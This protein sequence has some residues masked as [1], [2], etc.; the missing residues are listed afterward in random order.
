MIMQ[1]DKNTSLY[2]SS[3]V[4]VNDRELVTISVLDTAPEPF[5]VPTTTFNFFDEN[6]TTFSTPSPSVSY[7]DISKE[8]ARHY[9]LA[10]YCLLFFAVIR[11]LQYVFY[12][13]KRF[14][15]WFTKPEYEAM[16]YNAAV[17]EGRLVQGHGARL[18]EFLLEDP[19]YMVPQTREEISDYGLKSDRGKQRQKKFAKKDER[20]RQQITS[21]VNKL[22]KQLNAINQRMQKKKDK[23]EMDPQTEIVSD[24][25][26]MLSELSNSWAGGIANWIINPTNE[27][28]IVTTLMHIEAAYSMRKDPASVLRIVLLYVERVTPEGKFTEWAQAI[29]DYL[30]EN[31]DTMIHLRDSASQFAT[32]GAVRGIVNAMSPH[33]EPTS[34][35][36]IKIVAAS[37]TLHHIK[38]VIG[39]LVGVGLAPRG[40]SIMGVKLFAEAAATK[41]SSCEDIFSAAIS[42]IDY[43]A[44]VGRK[45]FQSG[46]W[47]DLMFE[48]SLESVHGRMAAC[49]EKFSQMQGEPID[50]FAFARML[51]DAKDFIRMKVKAESPQGR[52]ILLRHVVT[53]DSMKIDVMARLRGFKPAKAPVGMCLHGDSSVGKSTVM[54]FTSQAAAKSLGRESFIGKTSYIN[55]ATKF[56]DTIN[57]NTE[58]IVE[59]DINYAMQNVVDGV[60][61]CNVMDIMNN[62][63][64]TTNQ[65]D[66][67][68]KGMVSKTALFYMSSCNNKRQFIHG[69][70]NHPE[71]MFRR[72]DAVEVKVKPAAQDVSGRLN[73]AFVLAELDVD[74]EGVPRRVPDTV[75]SLTYEMWDFRV[76]DYRPVF[77]KYGDVCQLSLD[78]IPGGFKVKDVD[79]SVYLDVVTHRV[80]D[81]DVKQQKIVQFLEKSIT[82]CPHGRIPQ[83]CKD[84]DPVAYAA[85]VARAQGTAPTRIRLIPP[86]SN[87]SAMQN[88]VGLADVKEKV[89]VVRNKAT[90]LKDTVMNVNVGSLLHSGSMGVLGYVPLHWQ[91][92]VVLKTSCVWWP[93]VMGLSKRAPSVYKSRVR[94]NLVFLLLSFLLAFAHAPLRHHLAKDVFY[95]MIAIQQL[96]VY[97]VWTLASSGLQ[98]VFANAACSVSKEEWRVFLSNSI[99]TAKSWRYWILGAFTTIV[100]SGLALK[101]VF[102]KNM[103]DQTYEV[104]FEAGCAWV[105][106]PSGPVPKADVSGSTVDQ[107]VE[108]MSYH[109][110]YITAKLD[111]GIMKCRAFPYKD[112][113]WVTNI[114]FLEQV[115]NR[116]LTWRSG[117]NSR[118]IRISREDWVPVRTG[119]DIGMVHVR[120]PT[121]PDLSRYV[122]H[123]IAID[124]FPA[125]WIM[126]NPD[127]TNTVC[128][129]R[130]Q[131]MPRSSWHTV[132]CSPDSPMY[133]I[134]LPINSGPGMCGSPVIS[135]TRKSIAVVGIHI[136]GYTGTPLVAVGAFNKFD[137]DSAYRKLVK[138]RIL[139]PDT[140][141]LFL[142]GKEVDTSHPVPLKSSVNHLDKGDVD[143][144][145]RFVVLGGVQLGDKTERL[146]GQ[147]SKS[148]IFTEMRRE[149]GDPDTA[150]CKY[151]QPEWRSSQPA[152]EH[153]G[154]DHDYDKR[155]YDCALKS[156]RN[157]YMSSSK[158]F[159]GVVPFTI[160]EYCKGIDR[161]PYVNGLNWNSS[162]GLP[163]CRS[164]THYS[165]VDVDDKRMI[166]Q[167]VIDEVNSLI[168]RLSVP[169]AGLEVFGEFK[170]KDE[171]TKLQKD[172]F[173]QVSP[174]DARVYVCYP[175]SLQIV[176]G[177]LFGPLGEAQNYNPKVFGSCVG[178]D[179]T[180][181]DATLVADIATR[182]CSSDEDDSVINGDYGHFDQSSTPEV[183][184]DTMQIDVDL[185]KEIEYPLWAVTCMENIVAGL[186]YPA[187]IVNGVATIIPGMTTSG[188]GYTIHANNK[189]CRF[190]LSYGFYSKYL[191][192]GGPKTD[193]T[194][195]V[196]TCG[197]RIEVPDYQQISSFMT[198]GDDHIGT[199]SPEFAYLSNMTTLQEELGKANIKYTDASKSAVN[200]RG[201]KMFSV[202]GDALDN[203]FKE[204]NAEFLKRRFVRT[205]MKF[206]DKVVET[207]SCPIAFRSVTKSLYWKGS[208]ELD[209]VWLEQVAHG[210]L[211]EMF[212]YGEA[213]FEEFKGKLETVL[214]NANLCTFISP[215]KG[216]D[217]HVRA[218]GHTLKNSNVCKDI[219]VHSEFAVRIYD[220]RELVFAPRVD[221][222]DKYLIL[223]DGLELDDLRNLGVGRLHGKYGLYPLGKVVDG[224]T[225]K[226]NSKCKLVEVTPGMESDFVSLFPDVEGDIKS[227]L[228]RET[229]PKYIPPPRGR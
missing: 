31:V 133:D 48:N 147:T 143:V 88:Q 163:W 219:R 38:K 174:K 111:V 81:N 161:R 132:P 34:F 200:K 229:S 181:H 100:L 227:S 37:D 154:V 225:V 179:V 183:T 191:R 212:F 85:R 116:P 15:F 184:V 61:G 45:Y 69:S 153:A 96:V 1:Q 59:D 65:A 197:H 170:Y 44:K 158:L 196:L 178:L 16:L 64:K 160:E 39:I 129:V 8:S 213:I 103:E 35:E 80:K 173:G 186:S 224:F 36:K 46:S 220:R 104:P 182:H 21:K 141:S 53:L 49:S 43:F 123:D 75:W 14:V 17:V 105:K 199:V 3:P 18:V 221:L 70:L 55:S 156:V 124:D 193:K 119:S 47:V 168:E 22:Q 120:F 194:I 77:F 28:T 198:Q 26:T 95:A 206:D 140:S 110:A 126:K 10:M 204:Q 117:G 25:S 144:S 89:N 216:F 155:A 164:K 128:D 97:A 135:V 185:A 121:T 27:R 202:L 218:Y 82:S 166:N 165:Y 101:K 112:G 127:L 32:E 5:F 137:L 114:H 138:G 13:L 57:P 68:A 122:T 157:F 148:C 172:V 40:A 23:R 102:A 78:P 211:R 63:P 205:T 24:F 214:A 207:V 19:F 209:S 91:A 29:S 169:G 83:L 66:L 41:C 50:L 146:R 136:A 134:H 106:K 145:D 108:K 76:K 93:I 226:C 74:D 162:M 99:Q 139:T 84:C 149:F 73:S 12:M 175:V 187:V 20:Q 113:T 9:L 176:I 208:Y 180:S 118:N 131:I 4:F 6:S 130:C 223:G 125:K 190:Y 189:I 52:A 56:D 51:D 152:L 159:N 71:A 79:L 215:L 87:T 7:R 107:L 203:L 54:H 62:Y 115:E 90:E 60:Q 30:S 92:Y 94:F 33:T 177:M 72:V 217:D 192:E 201:D 67:N 150:P 228:Y 42:A 142:L 171:A 2:V 109:T 222:Y 58:C 151:G 98:V 188:H 195:S 210:A 167:E 11:V 86:T